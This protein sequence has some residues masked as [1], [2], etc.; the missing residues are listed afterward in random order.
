MVQDIVSSCRTYCWLLQYRNQGRLRSCNFD[1]VPSWCCFTISVRFCNSL[2][3]IS[4]SMFCFSYRLFVHVFHCSCLEMV[5]DETPSL[6]DCSPER[7][8]KQ[9]GVSK[10]TDR[11]KKPK[12]AN[13]RK[14]IYYHNII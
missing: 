6:Y 2:K 11:V 5:D 4:I 1:V 3:F 10:T 9:V 12:S 8:F 14:Q 13:E 7:L